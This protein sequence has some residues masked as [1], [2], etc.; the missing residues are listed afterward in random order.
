MAASEPVRMNFM[1][2]YA[3]QIK[4]YVKSIRTVRSADGNVMDEDHFE[5][6]KYTSP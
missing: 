6:V 5:L 2:W 4:R 1:V 3:P